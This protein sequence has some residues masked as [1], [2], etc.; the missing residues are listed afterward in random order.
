[1]LIILLLGMIFLIK[2]NLSENSVYF[3][4]SGKQI[5]ENIKKETLQELKIR[6][7]IDKVNSNENI[8]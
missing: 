3:L 2:A 4:L 7:K 5:D 1:M 6:E 8:L